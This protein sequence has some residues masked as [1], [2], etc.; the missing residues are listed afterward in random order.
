[1]SQGPGAESLGSCLA[2]WHQFG[3]LGAC[4]R[5]CCIRDSALERPTFSL[6]HVSHQEENR[7]RPTLSKL[8]AGRL[9]ASYDCCHRCREEKL[10]SRRAIWLLGVWRATLLGLLHAFQHLALSQLLCSLFSWM[11]EPDWMREAFFFFFGGGGAAYFCPI[12]CCSTEQP[13]GKSEVKHHVWGWTNRVC[14]VFF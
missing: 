6:L 9:E 10:Q 14:F 4:S 13:Q 8:S 1:M 12:F 5:S 3:W 7:T 11:D 2:I